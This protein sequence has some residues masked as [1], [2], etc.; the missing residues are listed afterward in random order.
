MTQA[1]T[2]FETAY[3]NLITISR[4]SRNKVPKCKIMP[5]EHFKNN[6]NRPYMLHCYDA[7]KTGIICRLEIQKY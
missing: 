7:M 2:I 6:C 3:S 4:S 5:L 1:E